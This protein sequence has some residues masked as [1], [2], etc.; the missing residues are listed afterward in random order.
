VTRSERFL[1]RGSVTGVRGG[2]S[3]R[4]LSVDG[5]TYQLTE[6]QLL[7]L[8]TG[9]G[10]IQEPVTSL[11]ER[12]LFWICENGVT[13]SSVTLLSDMYIGDIDSAL[14]TDAVQWLLEDLNRGGYVVYTLG[15]LGIYT[16]I[17]PT[18]KAFAYMGYPAP[19]DI[20][21][22]GRRPIDTPTQHPGDLTDYRNMPKHHTRGGPIEHLT[23]AEHYAKYPD[24]IHSIDWYPPQLHT[25]RTVSGVAARGSQAHNGGGSAPPGGEV[26]GEVVVGRP[27]TMQYGKG[28]PIPDAVK[29]QV[30]ADRKAGLTWNQLSEK[31]SISLPALSPIIKGVAPDGY[32]K[33][34]PGAAVDAKKMNG[35]VETQEEVSAEKRIL[36]VLEKAEGP[37]NAPA[38]HARILADGLPQTP[39]TSSIHRIVHVLYMMRRRG[40]VEFEGDSKRTQSAQVKRIR[41]FGRRWRPEQNEKPFE[42]PVAPPPTEPAAQSAGTAPAARETPAAD[43]ATTTAP[44]TA[45]WPLLASLVQREGKVS[46]AA[47]LLRDAGMHDAADLVVASAS[48]LSPLEAEVLDLI[49]TMDKAGHDDYMTKLVT[50]SK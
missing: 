30:I 28:Q 22:A 18:P 3:T 2:A 48:D 49:R 16:R 23:R 40:L 36:A 33:R 24:H 12:L 50:S 14:T 8:A 44:A 20:V 21:Q 47:Q 15:A 17:R 45:R 25:L 46:Q 34:L 38:L 11:E 29:Q 32:K 43:T 27:S 7:A 13:F 9:G 31:H 6:R 1:L 39:T 37:M 5:R 26:K 41:L 35:A 4:H 10:E 42:V 19:T